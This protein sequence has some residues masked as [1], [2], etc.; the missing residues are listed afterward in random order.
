M[1]KRR[2]EVVGGEESVN[3]G[4]NVIVDDGE[5][6]CIWPLHEGCKEGCGAVRP[7]SNDDE[8]PSSV[9]SGELG[10]TGVDGTRPNSCPIQ[11]RTSAT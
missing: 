4:R 2:V 11:H 3:G 7:P 9:M 10:T 5:M 1:E 6:S 8:D